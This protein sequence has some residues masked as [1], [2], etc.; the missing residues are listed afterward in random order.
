[1]GTGKRNK[2]RNAL[3]VSKSYAL[4]FCADS[5]DLARD[6]SDGSGDFR[7]RLGLGRN[8]WFVA[9]IFGRCGFRFWALGVATMRTYLPV[10][11]ITLLIAWAF[12]AWLGDF[13]EYVGDPKD[14]IAWVKAKGTTTDRVIQSFIFAVVFAVIETAVLWC[15]HKL[16]A[17]GKP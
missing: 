6:A 5:P 4:Q 2:W 16:R 14:G 17:G 9:L 15:W 13:N 10:F 1:M 12:L 11:M 7:S 3:L 8:Y